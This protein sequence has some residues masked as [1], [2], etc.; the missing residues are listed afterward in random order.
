MSVELKTQ[1]QKN[2]KFLDQV[3]IS[4]RSNRYSKKTEESY[5]GWIKK[6]IVF[7]GKRHPSELDKESIRI[8]L[9]YLAVDRQVSASTQNQALQSILYLYKNIL[10]RELGWIEEIKFAHRKKHL[11]VVLT[12]EEVKSIIKNL[13][14]V[15]GLMTKLMYGSGMRL[16]ECLKL[17]LKDVDLELKIITIRDAKGEKDRVSVLPESIIEELKLHI[18]KVKNL[19]K[20]DKEKEIV[21]ALP[22]ALSKKYP[23][24]NKEIAWQYLFPAKSIVYNEDEKVKYRVHLHPSTYQKEFKKAVLK[25]EVTKQAT[26]HTLRHSFATHLLQNGYDIRTVQ[27]LLGHNSVKTT[28]IYTHVLNRGIGVRSP[29]D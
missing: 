3:R 15:V 21:V 14:G 8:F 5:V 27:E 17:R 29:L 2:V 16:G 24:A 13:E 4:L 25:A 22:Y 7:N 23:N 18:S 12:K 28:M 11:P 20:R 1:Q 6:Y 9:N 26:P 10:R 19:H